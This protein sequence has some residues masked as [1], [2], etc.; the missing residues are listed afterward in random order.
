MFMNI[1]LVI[2]YPGGELYRH[3][4]PGWL[5]VQLSPN[6][7]NKSSAKQSLVRLCFETNLLSMAAG[8]TDR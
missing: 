4:V 8:V 1:L 6:I 7:R 5:K 2:N 3:G